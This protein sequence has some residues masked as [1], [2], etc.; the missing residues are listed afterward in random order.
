MARGILGSCWFDKTKCKS[1]L[2]ALK[3][4]RK[5]Y[6][7]NRKVFKSRPLHDWSSNGADAFLQFAVHG[8]T[9]LGTSHPRA[10]SLPRFRPI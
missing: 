5:E 2:E 8:K 10:V 4:Y 7:E 3:Q 1:G 9:V 6:D